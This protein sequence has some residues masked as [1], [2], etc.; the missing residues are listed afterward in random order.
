MRYL[1]SDEVVS[2][3]TDNTL[4]LWHSRTFEQTRT[5]SGHTNEKNFVGLAVDSEFIAC[6][7]ETNEVRHISAC[8]MESVHS[9]LLTTC[10]CVLLQ[11][12]T[13]VSS[14]IQ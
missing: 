9:Y 7:S 14:D 13:L 3:S 2:A 12:K 4:R 8:L 6:G 11:L 10:P 1:N 5:F